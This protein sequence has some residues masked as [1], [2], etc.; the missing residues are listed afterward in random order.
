M[1]PFDFPPAVRADIA[2]D[3]FHH[4]SPKVQR[5]MEVLW[6]T[7]HGVPRAEVVRLSGASRASVQ[8]YLDAYRDGGLDAVRRLRY[9]VPTSALDPHAPTLEAHFRDHPP[10][11]TADARATIQRM[12][13]IRRGLTQV[14]QFLKKV[15]P[16]VPQGPGRPGQGRPGHSATV[17]GRRTAAPAGRG[18]RR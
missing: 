14:R 13:G 7:A 11:T 3:R 4:P 1:R 10:R 17:P 15:G 8:R 9:V 16:R 12:A 6:L 5:R 2:A 18:G